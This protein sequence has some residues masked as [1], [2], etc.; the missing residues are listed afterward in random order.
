MVRHAGFLLGLG[1]VAG[2]PDAGPMRP[3][4]VIVLLQRPYPS[5]EVLEDGL[6]TLAEMA[7][8]LK[9]GPLPGGDL[10]D[11]LLMCSVPVFLRRGEHHR[12]LE[13]LRRVLGPV[14]CDQLLKLARLHP[15]FSFLDGDPPLADAGSRFGRASGPGAASRRIR[16]HLMRLPWRWNWKGKPLR[17][18]AL[19]KP[20]A[21][22]KAFS[23]K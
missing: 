2:D 17:A 15:L 20:C 18:S 9:D 1:R 11:T 12:C 8:P 5:A 19:R 14:R 23:V 6:L 7:A 10:E 21:R 13:Q 3:A 16:P 4:E 22:V